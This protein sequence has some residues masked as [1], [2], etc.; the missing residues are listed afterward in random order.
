V[1]TA[2]MIEGS[3]LVIY[4]DMGHNIPD[5]VLPQ[6]LQKMTQHMQAADLP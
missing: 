6:L 5:A 2:E 4:D 3:E 1:H